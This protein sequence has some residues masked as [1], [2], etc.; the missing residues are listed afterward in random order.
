MKHAGPAALRSLETLLVKLRGLPGLIEKKPGIFYVKSKA[1]LH[2]H[3]D[4]A[5]LFADARLM[6]DEFERFP[7]N[8]KKQQESLFKQL[9]QR[10]TK[11]LLQGH[12]QQQGDQS[13]HGLGPKSTLAL[14]QIG[15]RSLEELRRRDVYQVYKLLKENAPGTSLNFMYALIGAV[16]GRHWLEVQRQDRTEILRRLDD[17]GLAPK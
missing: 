13:L 16:E 8:T 17:M 10:R 6:S 5:G 4:P 1:Y 2:F 3:E 11:P 14:A 7:V 12:L 15:I 9:V